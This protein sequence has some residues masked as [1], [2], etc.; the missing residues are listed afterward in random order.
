MSVRFAVGIVMIASLLAPAG[1]TVSAQTPA[2][3]PAAAPKKMAP[4]LRGVAEVGYMMSAKRTATSIV[5]TFELKN[6]SLTG[7][8]VGLQITQYFYDKARNPL[9]GTGDRQRL[10][11]PL[12]PGEVATIVL[13]SPIVFGMTTPQ[14]KFAHQNGEVKPTLLKTMK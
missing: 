10:R 6:L 13:T 3:A 12:G 5:T 9:Q 8:I 14:H 4:P 7:S 11:M 2:P 1:I